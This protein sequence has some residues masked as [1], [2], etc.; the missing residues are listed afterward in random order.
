MNHLILG[1]IISF[2]GALLMMYIGT[3]RE[4]RKILRLQN[5]QFAI[6][7]MGNLVLGGV[8]G[9][10]SNLVC[11]VR[12]LLCMRR[13]FTLGWR[14]GFVAVQA[15]LTLLFNQAGLIGLLP[16]AAACS[17]TLCMGLNNDILLKLSILFG[18]ICWAVYDLHFRNY[19]SLTFDLLTVGINAVSLIGMLR[20]RKNNNT[21][22]E[23]T[24]HE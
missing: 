8:T 5:V 11:I 4:E 7:G 2:V 23:C 24:D 14:L 12:N 6:M 9:G 20:S 17:F 19:A 1:N 22:Q 15:V 16:L 21:I 3:L 13:P 10:V 18:Q